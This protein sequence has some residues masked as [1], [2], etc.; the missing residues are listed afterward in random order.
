MTPAPSS[1][2]DRRCTLDEALK[3]T[4]P[5]LLSLLDALPEDS[6]FLNSTHRS[7]ASAPLTPSSGCCCAK[8]GAAPTAGL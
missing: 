7:A 1:Q 2:S 4:L 8:S 5:A 3:D 6:P